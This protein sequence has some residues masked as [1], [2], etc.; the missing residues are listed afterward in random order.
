MEME[1]VHVPVGF[2]D[3]GLLYINIKKLCSRFTNDILFK[4]KASGEQGLPGL[5]K[6]V[7][8]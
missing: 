5:L 8:S 2:S 4:V 6:L 3:S 1:E 7:Q